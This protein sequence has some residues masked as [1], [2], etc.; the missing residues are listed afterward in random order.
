MG[1]RIMIGANTVIMDTNSHNVPYKD[2][3]KRWDKDSKKT[4]EDRR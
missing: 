4:C 1:N 2:R 3:L